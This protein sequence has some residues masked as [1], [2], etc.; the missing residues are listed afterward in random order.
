MEQDK[1]NIEIVLLDDNFGVRYIVR[2]FLQRLGMKRGVNI[3]VHTSADGVQGLGY[4]FTTKPNIIVVDTTLPQYSGREILEYLAT[5]PNYTSGQRKIIVIHDGQV[6]LKLPEQYVVISK[7]DKDFLSKVLS[8]VSENIW[9]DQPQ[10]PFKIRLFGL[11]VA[12]LRLANL[13]ERLIRNIKS[14]NLLLK[15]LYPAWIVVQM[16]I[17]IVLSVFEIALP[18][19]PDSNLQQQKAD[20]VT[21]RVKHYPTLITVL[22]AL[23][24]IVI[25][26]AGYIIGGVAIFHFTGRVD[27]VQATYGNGYVYR[28]SI[29]ID[30]TKVM[31][32]ADLTNYPAMISGTYAYLATTGN[33]GNVTNA[34]G[35]DI[36]F[37]SDAAGSTKLDHEIE[38]YV[39]TT[40]EI[41]MWV[42]IPT[43]DYDNDTTIY[44]FY[45]NS[46]VT[47]SQ[48]AI[49][50]TWNSN[51]GLVAHLKETSGDQLDSTSNNNDF[52][53]ANISVTAK[54]SAVGKIGG[55]NDFE[56]SSN[57]LMYVVDANNLNYNNT[58]TLSAWVK[59]E[60]Q[61]GGAYATIMGRGTAS[62]QGYDFNV[63]DT[64][65]LELYDDL[66]FVDSATGVITDGN[67]AY[68]TAVVSSDQA[69]F[70]VNGA[71]SGTVNQS[72]DLASS[73]T[74]PT[75]FTV[76]V[77]ELYGPTRYA[78]YF[79]GIIDEVRASNVAL[80]AGWIQTD[81]N[82]QNSPSTFYIVGGAETSLG[83]SISA[84]DSQV[85]S[86]DIPTSNV[87]L[88]GKFVF[89]ANGSLNLTGVTISETGSVDAQAN[90]DNIKL[91]YDLDSSAPYD[92]ASE[93]YGGSESQ[94][95]STDAD[96]FSGANGT[97]AFTGSLAVSSTQ[98]VCMYVVVDVGSGAVVGNTVD[99]QITAPLTDIT[100]S[101]G[102][103][104]TSS[105]VAISGSTT[106]SIDSVFANGYDFRR[107]IVIDHTKVSGSANITDFP[108]LINGTFAYLATTGNGGDVT[109]SNG[110]DIIFTSDAS[111]N[112]VLDHEIERYVSTTGQIVMWVKIPTLSYTVDTTIYMF[113]GNASVSTSQEDEN[114]VWSNNF[115]GVWHMSESSGTTLEDSSSGG[116][117]LI[118]AS[119]T[120][121]SYNASG[122]ANGAQEYDAN[123]DQ[124]GTFANPSTFMGNASTSFTLQ[125]SFYTALG[126]AP[127]YWFERTI[128]GADAESTSCV[129][130]GGLKL[131]YRS[132][133]ERRLYFMMPH[134]PGSA[135]Q[136]S[137]DVEITATIDLS[138]WY[139]VAVTYDGATKQI[140]TYVN[141]T[142]GG[143]ATW[144]G[145]GTITW[146]DGMAMGFADY[147]GLIDEIRFSNV[148]RTAGWVA[149]NHNN[150]NSP[151]T[152]YSLGGEESSAGVTV[153][154]AG[155]QESSIEFPITNKYV[156]GKF[157]ITATN[158]FTLNGVTIAEQGTVDAQNN[159]D[160]IKL[161]YDLDTSAP[162]DCT[163]EA[164]AGSESQ[165]GTTD[166]DGFS[167]ANGT[168]AFTGS[169][170]LTSTQTACVYVVLDVS[171]ATGAG[172]TLDIQ[173]TNPSTQVTLVSGSVLPTT[174]IALSGSTT[175]SAGLT[176]ANGYYN[177]RKITID[178]TKVPGTS[179]LS[180]FPMLINGTYTYLKT[181]ANG[182]NVLNSNGYDIIFTSDLAGNTQLPHE[183]ENYVGTTGEVSIWVRIPT[184]NYDTATDIYMFYGKPSAT[185]TQ[186][187]TG[188]W[189]PYYAGVWH[190]NQAT[191]G[192]APQF[193]DSFLGS[194]N[195]TSVNLVSGDS[196][197]GMV[198]F[199]KGV[200]FDGVNKHIRLE[201][202]FALKPINTI[203]VSGWVNSASIAAD[204][205][206]LCKGFRTDGTWNTP[207]VT[208]C[209]R[210]S[211][212]STGQPMFE[213]TT[214]SQVLGSITATSPISNSAWHY[215]VGVY[216]GSNLRIYV[217][218]VEAGTPVA[219]SGSIDYSGASPF[220]DLAIGCRSP[221]NVSNCFNGTIDEVRVSNIP[222]SAEWIQAEYYNVSSP[223]T[224]YVVDNLVSPTDV[225]VSDYGSQSSFI[226]MPVTNQ[227]VGGTF[228][229]SGLKNVN[230]TGI[231]INELGT[232]DGQ[233]GL[234]NIK[235]YYDLDTTAP[236]NCASESYAGSETQFGSTDTDGFSGANGS[237]T[238]TGTIS[239]TTTQ[240]ACVYVVLDVV[241]V[242]T[243]A[244]T[245]DI[246]ITNSVT[247]V[248]ISGTTI[249]PSTAV[250]LSGTTTIDYGT[251]F[252]IY[253]GQLTY[254]VPGRA[255]QHIG[256]RMTIKSNSGVKAMT[257]ITITE[258]GTINAQ[259]HLN[260][261]RLTYDLD[262]TAPYDCV[263]ETRSGSEPQYGSTDT[264]GF[265]AANGTT[266]FTG[267]VNSSPTQAICMYLLLDVVSVGPTSGQTIEIE[268]SNPST[269]IVMAS[270]NVGPT[271]AVLMTGTTVIITSTTAVV[272]TSGTQINQLSTNVTDRYIG[273]TFI[274]TPAALSSV[275]S[276]TIAEQGTVNAQTN[277]DN[278]KLYYDLDTTSPYNCA[279]ELFDGNE[280]QYGVTD[281]DGFDAASGIS[282]FTSITNL[283]S[284]TQ[285]MCVYVV[286]DVTSGATASQ[287]IEIQITNPSTQ[288]SLGFGSVTPNTAV[289]IAGTT[290]LRTAVTTLN[291]Q[292]GAAAGNGYD[293]AGNASYFTTSP[294]I[295][296][297]KN[298]SGSSITSGSRFTAVTIPRAAE[299]LTAT[300]DF[301]DNNGNNYGQAIKGKIYADDVDNSAALSTSALPRSRTLTTAAVDWDTNGIVAAAGAWMSTSVTAPPPSI[302][303]VVQEVIDRGLWV[304]GNAM[305]IIIADDGS[306]TNA[307]LLANNYTTGTTL[308]PRLAVTYAT[309]AMLTTVTGTQKVN[310]YRSTTNQHVGG[311]FVIK[312]MDAKGRV[313][314]ITI[315][316]QGTVDALNNL[317]N[318]KL[319]Y[320]IDSTAPY[321]CASETYAGTE[322]QFGSTVAGG[323]S[324]A[325][326]TAAF[327]SAVEMTVNQAMC[328]YP[329]FDIQAGAASGNTIEIQITT[330]S[331]QVTVPSGVS[332]SYGTAAILGTTTILINAAPSVTTINLN[333]GSNITLN[334]GTTTPVVLTGV[335]TD[336][337]G[338]ATIASA[339]AKIY[340]TPLNNTCTPDDNNC[341][342]L[343][344]GV[345]SGCTGNTCNVTFTFNMQYF[346]DPTDT[347]SPNAAQTWA[348]AITGF[349][350]GGLSGAGAGG[351][352]ELNSLLALSVTGTITYGSLLPGDNSGS[353][354]GSVVLSNTG[355][356]AI[357]SEISGS[358]LCS[359]YPTC[360]AGVIPVGNQQYKTTAFTYGA[361][362]ALSTT[363][364]LTQI[365]LAKPT[366]LSNPS[367][368]IYWGISLPGILPEGNYTGNNSIIAVGD[369]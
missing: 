213:V 66:E 16:A 196:V 238:F 205:A 354:N 353:T 271:T 89:T 33:G 229:F 97:S 331:S 109:N 125:T 204:S 177:R 226:Q 115:T 143:T 281:T 30:N 12:T 231:T 90:L 202:N 304:S 150:L 270:G 206:V 114:G 160:N 127:G 18:P 273:G 295:L 100:V 136:A 357:D 168:S 364:T 293:I 1:R 37:T 366:S 324:A 131:Q 337:N 325:N 175:L 252:S 355:N 267:S 172:E 48:E 149:T 83:L 237:S 171:A 251:T 70:Y 56:V 106:L 194:N 86:I 214:G 217:D 133:L 2:T 105:P 77:L 129:S 23:S 117:D 137:T 300:I 118:K 249:G 255:D 367:S 208:Y 341:Y 157:V 28:R 203:T 360:A 285:V 332:T 329:V 356:R 141:G 334:E 176:Y 10:P 327:S 350:D 277:L 199:A 323:F 13:E 92:C 122:R 230:V 326:G 221:F 268:I 192:S 107:E 78:D 298:V 349:D 101:T 57:N 257:S 368:T 288:V 318:I 308:A 159:L 248:T 55:A 183:I 265:S 189:T 335:I 134:H 113:Y 116:Y 342:S 126:T 222:R 120:D 58:M 362:T 369:Q 302:V 269:D 128:I 316:E 121:P 289:A 140:S 292:V 64:A 279:S 110:Y 246:Q 104:A 297:G 31:G 61:A 91:F 330:P 99:V 146:F 256:G 19:Q 39:A 185:D 320:E 264:N 287:T 218:G 95:G 336:T 188:I 7:Q 178:H 174:P 219:K 6:Q 94:F 180:G 4:I 245:L 62:S 299:I 5:N 103:I 52:L 200:N 63:T 306:N 40:G 123:N 303:S 258:N 266:T 147:G 215:L 84:S 85:S 142:A 233:V 155:T 47:T 186:D 68:V 241:S 291:L 32:S 49:T 343:S 191:T 312:P 76:G 235:L 43:L 35:Y 220:S 253:G 88:G 80:T 228:V 346:S 319:F 345:L 36:I 243:P 60:S 290:T 274:I 11:A 108:M 81:Y 111:G 259:S 145:T 154:A 38:R 173:I 262:V 130:P 352:V 22:V 144:G 283:I 165:F 73:L 275:S 212:A 198:G 42:R 71:T 181:T 321:D 223:S 301:Q 17:S 234:D 132:A 148:V 313:N 296:T 294:M 359:D 65:A 361:G 307:G 211:Q 227:H 8:E 338:F 179:A 310:M 272:S 14:G 317:K 34:N 72:F 156:G 151:S 232:V 322:T 15:L 59:R 169:V 236:Y 225:I 263:S 158:N 93:S 328:V 3:R 87:Y 347:G 280:T 184:V 261:M 161:Y 45:N 254:A 139:D 119:A 27:R 9:P 170:A 314:G 69:T 250:A 74:S 138:T 44:M 102:S 167:G 311:A 242:A 67:W 98:A 54:G 315:A 207:F 182:G 216:D 50:G 278:I 162:Y 309:T 29:T 166:T 284:T 195:G 197:T 209:L 190:M 358:N 240:T 286:L 282:T 26:V 224:F 46:S 51:Y 153:S 210:A 276:I 201:D 24:L 96:G 124:A 20:L 305:T 82:N 163:S 365:S 348:A 75:K 164:Y 152:F 135:C 41:V 187:K 244:S 53:N 363:P 112:T 247:D 79:D 344:N 339:T 340:R 239:L 25:Q 21:F 351:S 333:G 193:Y 260:N